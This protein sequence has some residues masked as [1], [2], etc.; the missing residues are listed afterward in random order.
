MRTAF[1]H[2]GLAGC[3][4]H[5]AGTGACRRRPALHDQ[6]QH[7]VLGTAPA[8]RA[9]HRLRHPRRLRLGGRAACVAAALWPERCAGL[10]SVNGY[11]IQHIAGASNSLRRDL[12]A[13]FWY[14]YFANERGR[15]GLAADRR[16]IAKD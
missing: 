3:L 16:D 2:D 5:D 9:R 14:F 1:S 11:L 13:G 7:R 6:V 15:R 10:V 8:E 12:E 4:A